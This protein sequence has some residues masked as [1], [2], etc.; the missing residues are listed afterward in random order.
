M[1]L[2]Q[3]HTMD[4]VTDDKKIAVPIIILEPVLYSRRVQWA[5]YFVLGHATV[6][7]VVFASSFCAHLSQYRKTNFPGINS[8]ISTIVAYTVSTNLLTSI[9]SLSVII[10]CATMPGSFTFLA[11]EFL[12]TKLYVNSY[13]AMLNARRFI[14]RSAGLTTKST[15]TGHTVLEFRMENTLPGNSSHYDR[16]GKKPVIDTTNGTLDDKE[17]TTQGTV[18]GLQSAHDRI[19]PD[20]SDQV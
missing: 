20:P 19:A 17:I 2:I 5:G 16:Y 14:K 15:E 12:L 11:V 10:L 13:M 4:N 3:S 9:C 18:L 8:A 6:L 7:D 1:T